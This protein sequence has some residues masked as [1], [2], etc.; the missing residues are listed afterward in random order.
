MSSN[1]SIDRSVVRNLIQGRKMCP[2]DVLKNHQSEG[3]K[4][5]FNDINHLKELSDKLAVPM[6]DFFTENDLDNGVKIS[7]KDSSFGRTVEKNGTKYYTYNH[8]AT[9]KTEPNLM[10]LR[11]NLHCR[12]EDK[13]VLNGGHDSKEI[14]YVTKGVVRMDW[15]TKDGRK[16]VELNV[17][18]SAYLAPGVSH[19][20]IALVDDSELIAVNY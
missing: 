3:D 15:E 18:D 13:I 11:V 14:I 17:G 4:I 5:I 20:F 8:L 2:D 6:K 10:A 7:R 16:H 9:T 19:S 1:L 12:D